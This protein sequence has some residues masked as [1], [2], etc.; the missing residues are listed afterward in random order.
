MTVWALPTSPDIHASE[1]AGSPLEELKVN[2]KR[3]TAR[4]V[5]KST[6]F[7]SYYVCTVYGSVFI[8]FMGPI[9]YIF[10]IHYFG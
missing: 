7:L 8:W 6:P 1:N 5:N 9:L 3:I 4:P 2:N 10:N